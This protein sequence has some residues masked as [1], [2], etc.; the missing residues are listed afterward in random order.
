MNNLTLLRALLIAL[1]VALAYLAWD[2]PSQ[3][4]AMRL[5]EQKHSQEVCLHELRP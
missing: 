4:D 2:M 5:C 3:Q 1:V